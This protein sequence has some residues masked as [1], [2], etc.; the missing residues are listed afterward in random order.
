MKKLNALLFFAAIM[1]SLTG[2][3]N[4][5]QLF[6]HPNP[7]AATIENGFMPYSGGT[8]IY[9]SRDPES[10]TASLIRR[11]YVYLGA[12]SFEGG[13]SDVS[14]A[15][16]KEQA[17]KVGADVVLSKVAF[18]GSEQRV[19][20]WTTYNPGTMSMTNSNGMVT[21]TAK[22]NQGG[23]VYGN[24]NYSGSSLTMTSGTYSTQMVPVTI[25]KYEWGATFWR[26]ATN[27]ILGVHALPLT[28]ELRQRLQRNTGVLVKY[29]VENSPA[30]RANILEGDVIMAI[31][32]EEATSIDAFPELYRKAAGQ[33]VTISLIRG[34]EEKQVKVKFNPE[35]HTPI[36]GPASKS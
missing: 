12:S 34:S 5:Y 2:C 3:V 33:T 27:P 24:A 36:P 13:R 23:A 28:D 14:H 15:Q 17:V 30:F 35:V 8:D 11:G 31:N 9:S 29:V 22:N 25:N 4:Y 6:Y 20:P 16:L 19:V 18:K 10:D 26:K 1:F 32:D 21:A 7:T